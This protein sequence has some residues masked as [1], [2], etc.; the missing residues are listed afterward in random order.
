VLIDIHTHKRISS[1]YFSV[2]NLNRNFEFS[3]EKYYV[4]GGLH[5]WYLNPSTLAEQMDLLWQFASDPRV[6]FIG[7]CGLDKLCE[8]D[9][10]LQ[11]HAFEL[12]IDLANELQKPLIIHCVKAHNEVLK[13]LKD[14]N[15]QVPV[16]FHGYNKNRE[17]AETILRQGY[18]IS[19]GA[20]L[21][22]ERVAAVFQSIPMDR[23]FFESDDQEMSILDL[24]S[25][26]T[27][28][29]NISIQQLEAQIT[30][31]LCTILG[32]EFKVL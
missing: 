18:Y 7:E 15:N 9:F 10:G 8:I 21:L 25:Y 27:G 24:Y 26:A 13:L 5:P 23:I 14:K 11:W 32:P 3:E 31:N 1:E 20:D 22:K 30:T 12:Q 2:L 29:M 4:S 6:L 28:L 17:I 19:F 16:V